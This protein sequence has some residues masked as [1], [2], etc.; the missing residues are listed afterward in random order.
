VILPPFELYRPST[1]QEALEARAALG[2]DARWLAGGTQLLVALKSGEV[3]TPAL[4]DVTRVAD[5][6][7]ITTSNDG[8]LRIGS[9]ATYHTIR[10]D[11]A[12]RRVCAPLA[13]LVSGIGNPRVRA[14]GT[15]GGN[16]AVAD[17]RT[18]P[19][20][21]LVALGAD[22]GLASAEG[23]RRITVH[24]L[25]RG[26]FA[27][28]MVD[29]ELLTD[30]G[31][32]APLPGAYLKFQLSG[33]LALG[34]AVAGPVRDGV[35]SAPPQVVVGAAV[36]APTLCPEAAALLVDR[37]LVAGDP[38]VRQAAEAAAEEVDPFSDPF[39][40]APYKRR[41]VRALLPR[42]IARLALE[43]AA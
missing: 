34:L 36:T 25:V 35:F 19:I 10:A 2:P 20:T 43:E 31:V 4:V 13:R 18:D 22:V 39:A 3:S 42:A 37:P 33:R 7:E 28:A 30:V 8:G 6:G 5:L 40:S 17:P 29:G 11:P 26:P 32:A 24:E 15:L 38:G 23:T 41:L 16:L 27:T 14:V 1:L 12:V 9:G 21:L